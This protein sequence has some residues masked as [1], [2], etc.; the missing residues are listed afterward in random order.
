MSADDAGGALHFGQQRTRDLERRLASQADARCPWGFV[1][2]RPKGLN[3]IPSTCHL[4]LEMTV[5][6]ELSPTRP[7]GTA[8]QPH[9]A[10]PAPKPDAI[11]ATSVDTGGRHD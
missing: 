6:L 9:Q 2:R 7:A 11:S 3:T 8:Q 1:V 10:T 4:N 5:T